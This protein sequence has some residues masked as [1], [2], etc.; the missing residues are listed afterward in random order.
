[1][2]TDI[3]RNDPIPTYPTP[4]FRDQPPNVQGSRVNNARQLFSGEEV[5]RSIVETVTSTSVSESSAPDGAQAQV[6]GDESNAINPASAIQ[7]QP[8]QVQQ[9]SLSNNSTSPATSGTGQNVYSPGGSIPAAR[10]L[11]YSISSKPG[12]TGAV[13]SASIQARMPPS[14]GSWGGS[15]SP[16]YSKVQTAQQPYRILKRINEEGELHPHAMGLI[17]TSLADAKK[18]DGLEYEENSPSI[19]R[20][21]VD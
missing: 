2:I 21:V 3:G 4:A 15:Y 20:R 9:V 18:L 10:Q 19:V 6:T 11:R 14:W 8:G 7:V 16:T 1:M 17:E 13:G 5:G 12:E